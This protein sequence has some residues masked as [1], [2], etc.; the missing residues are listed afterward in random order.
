MERKHTERVCAQTTGR[1][2]MG[3][4]IIRKGQQLL[5]IPAALQSKRVSKVVDMLAEETVTQVSNVR[6]SHSQILVQSQQYIC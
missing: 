6:W 3:S 2:E 1:E 5:V 4:E